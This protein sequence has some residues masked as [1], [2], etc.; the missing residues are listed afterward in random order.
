MSS[1]SIEW[2][3]VDASAPDATRN[4]GFGGHVMTERSETPMSDRTLIVDTDDLS[5]RTISLR[6]RVGRL[7]PLRKTGTY[8]VVLDEPDE[9]RQEDDK[10][11]SP[12]S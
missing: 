7:V 6:E 5:V 9:P 1:A 8:V 12:V 2:T 3:A 10:T 11:V 4:V